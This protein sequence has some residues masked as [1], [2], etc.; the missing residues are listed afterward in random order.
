MSGPLR[1]CGLKTA[2]VPGNASSIDS[3][4]SPLPSPYPIGSPFNHRIL[5]VCVWK[6]F[7]FEIVSIPTRFGKR[8]VRMVRACSESV[9][10][11][12]TEPNR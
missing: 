5:K 9:Q 7:L 11:S 6:S 10:I 2:S 1:E 12:S 8:H 4:A 3:L